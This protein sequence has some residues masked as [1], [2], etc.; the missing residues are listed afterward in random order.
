MLLPLEKAILSIHAQLNTKNTTMKFIA[1]II[2]IFMSTMLWSQ[3]DSI[4]LESCRTLAIERYPLKGDL[5]KNLE[6]SELKIQNIKSIYYPSLQ[7]TGQYTHLADVPHVIFESSFFSLPIVGKDQY[8]VAIDARQIIYDG[9]LTKRRKELENVSLQTDNQDI[10]VKLYQL[11]DQVNE[12]YFMILMFQEQNK[13]LGLTR[14]N[15]QEQLKTVESGVR[16]GVLM[17][18]DADILKAEILKLEQQITELNAGKSSGIEMLSEL[19]DTSLTTNIS[20]I[21]PVINVSSS[22]SAINRPEYKL[23]ELQSEKINKMDHLNKAYRFPYLGLFG[24]F[25]YGYPGMN[26]IEDKANIIYSFGVNLSWTIWDWGKV[27]RESRMNRIMSDK[28]ST[29]KA[30]FDKSLNMSVIQETDKIKQLEQSIKSDDEIIALRERIT[31]AKSSQLKNGVITSSEYI[32]EL[33]A[34]MQAK[35]N[36]E[37]HV[38]Q[39]L[40]SRTKLNTLKG[41]L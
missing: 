34:E 16:N 2:M 25:G 10:E 21:S 26:M 18:G 1:V 29:Q 7:L 4:D 15:L 9:G 28:I 8:K 31:G 14:T 27:K 39:L 35:I 37:L 22:D 30:L 11:N 36:K 5:D 41:N 38:I 6:T 17:P 19:M 20:L 13:L 23:L 24:Q 40:K 33:N 12:L 32:V 3:S